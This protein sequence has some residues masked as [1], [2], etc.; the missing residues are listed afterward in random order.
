M[1]R[2]NLRENGLQRMSTMHRPAAAVAFF[3]LAWTAAVVLGIVLLAGCNSGDGSRPEGNST[4]QGNVAS[5]SAG[6]VSLAPGGAGVDVRMLGTGLSTTTDSDGDFVMSG[7]PAGNHEMQFMFNDQVSTLEVDVPEDGILTLGDIRCVG[8]Q[9]AS[10]GHMNMQMNSNMGSG[11]M[12]SGGK[13]MHPG[14]T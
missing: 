6:A 3:H 4:V 14:G 5:F 9:S 12:N 8:Q 1:S 2:F 13:S 10:V 11:N 7:V